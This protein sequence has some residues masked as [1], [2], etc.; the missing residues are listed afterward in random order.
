MASSTVTRVGGVVIVTQ[1][2]PQSE[3]N[4]VALK[5]TP[6]APEATTTDT[7][8]PP[9][10]MHEAP[11]SVTEAPP[12]TPEKMD[13]MTT[14]FLKGEPVIMGVFQLFLGLVCFLF[15]LSSTF[16]RILLLHAPVSASALFV[17]A[18]AMTLIASKSVSQFS[19]RMAAGW[20]V[21]SSVLS[22]GGVAYLSWLLAGPRPTERLCDELDY[23]QCVN[24]NYGL[25]SLDSMV[26]GL[27]GLF[28]VLMTLQL[29]FSLT[30]SCFSIKAAQHSPLQMLLSDAES[31]ES[32][33]QDHSP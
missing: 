17:V 10:D 26:M 5:D 27:Q 4:A 8:A 1:V 25:W 19:V 18:G 9:T 31:D 15:S 28:L 23:E 11:S 6:K 32:L 29:V 30:V 20:S 2:I 3:Q 21:L 13:A 33:L 16:H 12:P 22:A 24:F 7:Q 14:T